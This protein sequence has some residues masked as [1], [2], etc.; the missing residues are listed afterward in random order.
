MQVKKKQY[1]AYRSFWP[2]L[3]TMKKF[4][5]TVGVDTFNVMISNTVNSLGFPYTKYPPVWK[6]NGVYDLDAFDKQ[7]DDVIRVVP[8][9]KFLC[10]LDLNTPPW[11]TR[12][13]GAFG[14]RY[15]SYYELGKIS[16]SELWRKDTAEYMRTVMKH[17]QECYGDR[18]E[19]YVL[20]CGGATEW[21]DRS[22]SEESVYRLAAFRKWQKAHNLPQTDIPGRFRRDS[23][24]YDF[25][26]DYKDVNTYYNGNDPTGGAYTEVFPNGFG[27]FRS[28]EKDRDVMD[29]FRFCNEFNAETVSFFLKRAREAIP[30]EVE[31]GCFFGYCFSAWTM[32]A[33][34]LAY[35]K[36]LESP[37]LDFVIA[38]VINYSIGDGSVS[39]TV[40]ET[41]PLH[42]KR[43]LQEFD[44]KLW[45][46]NRKLS[47]CCTLPDP[48]QMQDISWNKDN[49]GAELSKKFTFGAGNGWNTPER[50]AEGIKRDGAMA[51]INGDSLWWFDMW[52]GFYQ[53]REVFDALKRVKEIWDSEA[54]VGADPVAEILLVMDPENI[55]L[56][57]DMNERCGTFHT[58]PVHFLG[59]T[60]LPYEACSFRDLEKMDTARYK[61]V[62]L[63]HPF[64][65]LPEKYDLLQKKIL[66]SNRTILWM[67]G[68]VI[69]N[70]G[71]WN[72]SNVEKICGI[73]FAAPGV[74]QKRMAGWT[75]AYI[76]RPDR[77]LN[78]NILR[79]LAL[80]AGC[81]EWCDR[82][83]PLYANSRLVCVHTDKGERLTVRLRKKYARIEELFS[84]MEWTNAREVKLSSPDVKTFLLKLEE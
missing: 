70:S 38:P 42:G 81:H 75:S 66:N 83:R 18:I 21:H 46:Y 33:G 71:K 20:G 53:H 37:N 52:G 5:E 25:C 79:E 77:E 11:W 13:L 30:P 28:P 59:K 19:A 65:L 50:S 72:E 31:L 2:E 84:G 22:R 29:Y 47:D 49:G 10:M 12:Y 67:Y 3:E 4:R 78:E 26:T 1:F 27:L 54:G 74:P 48:N 6:W 80:Q 43:M 62:I 7:L 45:C 58:L 16:A 9:A 40:H 57:N 63:S 73:P 8:D 32:T 36:L 56:L 82:A 15:D 35:E 44:Q 41:V 61:F 76:Y 60:G 24:S 39:A 51:I 68:P 14:V 17:A 23:G 55:Y 34:H 64:R 69:D